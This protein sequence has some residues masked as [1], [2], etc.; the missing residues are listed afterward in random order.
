MSR[1]F[2]PRIVAPA[3]V[4]AVAALASPADAQQQTGDLEG[5]VTTADS[6]PIAGAK[7]TL[8][9]EANIGGDRSITTAD[10]G[11][12]RFLRLLPGDYKVTIEADGYEGLTTT[13][14]VGIGKT[15]RIAAP[16]KPAAGEG[17]EVIEVAAEKLAVD[18]KRIDVGTSFSAEFLQAVPSGRE[19]QS[20]AQFA[21]GVT[22]G[23]NPNVNGGADSSNLY[24]VDGVNTTDPT[25]NTFGLNFNFDAIEELQVLTGGFHPRYGN[26]TG[27]VIN[28]VTK[29]GSNEFKLDSSVYYTGRLL[30]VDS[31]DE[32]NLPED[33][34]RNFW[35]VGAN[36]NFSGPIIEDKLWYFV[37][38]EYNYSVSQL[39]SVS[40]F[41]F[42]NADL[43][44]FEPRPHPE[45]VYQS[46]YWLAKLTG[47]I[48]RHNRVT[49][50]GIADPASIDNASQSA[51]I[52][53]ESEYH[54]DQNGFT[55]KLDWEADYDPLL[56]QVKAG[57]KRSMLDVFPQERLRGSGSPFGFPGIF[58]FGELSDK[59][60]FGIAPG[61]LADEDRAD[62]PEGGSGCTDI[63]ASEEFGNGVHRV[64]G[65]SYRG[66][67]ADSFII[68][69]QTDVQAELS[70]LLD[71]VAGDHRID[72]GF[73]VALKSDEETE[74][75][76]GGAFF[77]D[78]PT[79]AAPNSGEPVVVP[80]VAYVIGSDDNELTLKTTGQVFSGYLADTWTF[81]D[82]FT[83][84]P[85]LRVD[86][87]THNDYQDSPVLDFLT[88]SPRIGFSIDPFDN[89]RTRVHG[90]YA[91]LYETGNLGLSKFVGTS[92]QLR[93]ASWNG[94]RYQ[95]TP[96]GVFVLGGEAGT[97][98]DKDNLDAMQTDEFRLGIEQAIGDTIALG[99]TYI[100]K[101][102]TNSWEDD[103][104]NLLWNQAGT[105]VIGSRAGDGQQTYRLKSLEQ[106][107]RTFDSLQLVFARKGNDGWNFN[108][109]YTLAWNRGAVN[110]TL[111]AGFDN[112]R[113]NSYLDGDLPD[114]VR[115]NFKAQG[116]HEWESGF[117]LGF[118]WRYETGTPY[119]PGYYNEWDS[120]YTNRNAPRGYYV[121]NDPNDPLDD[122]I[123]RLPDFMRL[124]ARFTYNLAPL[125][126]Q[127]LTFS[128]DVFNLLN[129]NAVTGLVT[130]A[131]YP[132]A[133]G[134]V[135]ATRFR[136]I[137]S[138]QSPLRVRLGLRYEF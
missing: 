97:T 129:Q 16:L 58:G 102:T 15:A 117:G 9:G 55:G 93:Y 39:P 47:Q 36:L 8:S 100:H 86:K 72:V 85:G 48:D 81:A 106:A 42:P 43:T 4:L 53:P 126:G 74:R 135:E 104:A 116:H 131:A 59:N 35:N 95:E 61:C 30:Q 20:A 29:S 31:P 23:G 64:G 113:Q 68:R 63:Q 44:D 50:L 87:A 138:F 45:R 10:D 17:V 130:N 34:R 51:S 27:G 56:I 118:A 127:K 38:T 83:L 57:Y 120:G 108:G 90:G 69:Q 103:E 124:D 7:V 37:S 105:D 79:G 82:R 40:P 125:T 77:I 18:T 33:Q 19:Y 76:P 65:V 52:A 1:F 28:V 112:P 25:T 71:D 54:Q 134:K 32:E 22:G 119:S 136:D 114:D 14:R 84:Q 107:K 99:V 88:I 98:I 80:A 26:V 67:N 111:T 121:G 94:E 41:E 49:L 24:L 11:G 110:D 78:V 128:A 123:Q 137:T 132:D 6:K 75:Y 66:T 92:L 122:R 5:T 96:G 89:G 62:P 60:N 2:D 46:F 91:R 133:E 101:Q 21:P 115:H 70:Y 12:F 13:L 3:A 73:Q 109:S